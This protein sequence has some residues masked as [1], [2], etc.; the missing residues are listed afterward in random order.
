MSVLRHYKLPVELRR[1]MCS[2]DVDGANAHGGAVSSAVYMIRLFNGVRCRTYLVMFL[3]FGVASI[4][5]F[6]LMSRRGLER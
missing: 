5:A 2:S 3:F 1:F 4:A 6:R